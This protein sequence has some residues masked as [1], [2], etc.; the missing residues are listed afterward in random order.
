MDYTADEVNRILDIGIALSKEKDRNKLLDMILDEGVSIAHCDAGTLYLCRENALHFRVM[1]TL[2]MQIDKG[3]NGEPIDLP[4]VPM[5]PQ[6][7]CAYTTP[8]RC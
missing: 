7:I 4:P 5:A 1:K 8:S 6:N 3:K 2:S